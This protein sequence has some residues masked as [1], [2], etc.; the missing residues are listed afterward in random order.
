[1]LYYR[2]ITLLT[3]LAIQGF[4]MA[5]TLIKFCVETSDSKRFLTT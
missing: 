5:Q 4:I 1:M 2:N 3:N